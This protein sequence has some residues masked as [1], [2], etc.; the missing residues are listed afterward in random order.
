MRV[1][2][3]LLF[4][5]TITAQQQMT[6]EEY[7]PKSGLTVPQH[8]KERA[9]YPFVDIHNHQGLMS[10]AEVDQL[11]REMDSINLRVMVNLSGGYGDRLKQ[12][13]QSLK[14]RYPDRFD[15]FANL[16]FSGMYGPDW[17]VRTD[18]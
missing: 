14:G 11:V 7:E 1:A 12:M 3:A 9:K 16:Y 5:V 10:A 15:V 18:W 13:V 2:A 17:S 6:I 8:P 4:A